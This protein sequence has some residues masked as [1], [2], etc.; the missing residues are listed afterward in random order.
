M[1]KKAQLKIFN[2]ADTLMQETQLASGQNSISLQ[3][4]SQGIYLFVVQ[5]GN[6]VIQNKVVVY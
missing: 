6:S 5:A 2:M 4:L 1:A 3:N